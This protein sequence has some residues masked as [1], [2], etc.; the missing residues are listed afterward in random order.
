MR[1]IPEGT[2]R[3]D[4]GTGSLLVGMLV[5]AAIVATSITVTTLTATTGTITTGTIT[6]LTVSNS[7]SIAD[8]S[9][10]A[11]L[12]IRSYSGTLTLPKVRAYNGDPNGTVPGAKG[13]LVMDT[14]TPAI[15]QNSTASTVWTQVG[16]AAQTLAG[17]FLVTG[18]ITPSILGANANDYAPTN[19]ATASVW[20][21]SASTSVSLSGIDASACSAVDGSV[22][23]LYNAG[24]F[25][26]LL[27][28]ESGNSTATNRLNSNAASMAQFVSHCFRY[29]TTSSRWE[30]F[31]TGGS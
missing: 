8:G 29:S 10:G 22:V 12:T 6:D 18:V 31:G 16:G 26:I 14:S 9:A 3:F 17:R 30:D 25:S 13:S 5:G 28:S 23:C 2:K 1:V 4:K 24:A 19:C 21:V 27:L 7:A 15:W 20:R 11:G